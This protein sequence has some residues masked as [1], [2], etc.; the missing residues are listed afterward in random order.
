[1]NIYSGTCGNSCALV[2][3]VVRKVRYGAIRRSPGLSLDSYK[4]KF[5]GEQTLCSPKAAILLSA[6]LGL[7]IVACVFSLGFRDWIRAS[8][9][10][11]TAITGNLTVAWQEFRCNWDQNK[12]VIKVMCLYSGACTFSLLKLATYPILKEWDIIA[13][14]CFKTEFKWLPKTRNKGT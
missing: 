14:W 5:N 9:L 13:L 1:M 12:C 10:A 2:S 8:P 11:T 6:S 7:C 4:A 3:G